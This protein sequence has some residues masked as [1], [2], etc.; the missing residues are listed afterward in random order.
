[1]YMN[2]IDLDARN[3]KSGDLVR[4]FN[5]RGEFTTKVL[6]DESCRPGN[7][8]MH[9]VANSRNVA[10]GVFQSITNDVKVP[11]QALCPQGYCISFNDVLV[12]VEKA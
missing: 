7:V 5:D 11:R 1:M 2:G 10:S 3:L 8:R 4:V 6:H 9:P 12:E